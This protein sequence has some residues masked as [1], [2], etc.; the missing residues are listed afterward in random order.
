MFCFKQIVPTEKDWQAIESSYD[1]TCFLSC[2]WM[3]GLEKIGLSPFYLAVF[4]D[5]KHVGYFVGERQWIGLRLVTS[6]LEGAGYSQ[7]L[8]MFS[9]TP[10]EERLTIYQALSEWLFQ[11]HLAVFFQVVDWQLRTDS[12]LWDDEKAT[13]NV[14]LDKTGI[15]YQIRR[16]LHLP[17]TK[18]I[19][20]LWSGLH[21]KSAKYMINKAKKH[22]LKVQ[23][24]N[25]FE[26]I[27][28]FIAIHY[29]QIKDVCKRKGVRP[30]VSQRK[31]RLIAFCN[32]MFP[33]RVLMIKVVGPDE[34]GVQQVM[35]TAVFFIDKGESIYWT[36][37]SFQC[38][39]MFS[40][41]ELM[42]WEA[43]QILHERGS[44][45]LNFGGSQTYKLKFGTQFAYV[46]RLFFAKYDC[47]HNVKSFATQ[48][49][50]RSRGWLVS[51]R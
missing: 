49:Y 46:P 42:V 28:P 40:P 48:L 3:C 26:E 31:K 6:P 34:S 32:A 1:S 35:S 17:L 38:Y 33:D 27:K 20:E 50:R 37:A 44:G 41:N 51:K 4:N 9:Y 43:I 8:V 24:V 14:L 39:Q 36:G 30:L 16:T 15:Q 11:N 45:D 25:R 18:T 23:I 5:D 13:K 29:A 7:G 21:Y 22:G 10:A 2:G 19:D 12:L 47:L